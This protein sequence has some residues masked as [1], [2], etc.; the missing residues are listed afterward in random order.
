MTSD[1]TLNEYLTRCQYKYKDVSKR[2]IQSALSYYKELTA[3]TERYTYP[4]GITRELVSL[5]GTI[6]VNFKNSRYN[7]PI[8][9]YLSD[10]HPYTPPIC[11]VRPTP[12]MSINSSP[13]S[14]V[15]SS[16]KISLPCLREWNYPQFDLYT[17]ISMMTIKFSEETP[18]FA[19]STR[20]QTQQ[21]NTPQY[22]QQS[23]PSLPYP[24]DIRPSY[25]SYS[26]LNPS[27]TPQYPNNN[28]Y[29]YPS[30][31]SPTPYP[32]VSNPYL[33]MQYGK[34]Q[35]SHL[36]SGS[37]NNIGQARPAMSYGYADETIGPEF[38]KNSLISAIE[39]K[40]RSRY[41]E[42][43]GIKQ[44]ENESLK[45]VKLDLESGQESLNQVAIQAQTE[46]DNLKSMTIELRQRTSMI[47][48]NIKAIQHRDKSN[49]EDAVITPMPL[50]RQIMLLY[51]EELAVQDLIY[52]LG[53]G[54]LN[55]TISL[56]SFLRQVRFLSRK[57]FT[58][59]ATLLKA[60]EKAALP[61]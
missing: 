22:P 10:L 43:E 27:N 15:D 25:P 55:N 16:G 61:L 50:Y 28:S 34:P 35:V 56:D 2:D 18:L 57:Q 40:V 4:N 9:L 47:N 12:D 45:K 60:R 17:L 44:A 33:P 13:T 58:L 3:I 1:I 20:P 21:F 48:E 36:K 46:I 54:L 6:P 8:Q 51:A 23:N 59:R 39:E 52:Y 42:M 30:S 53:E 14:S 32:Q 41:R 49:V 19:R 29:P 11:Y 31:T 7:I 38:I 37:G 5:K 24:A 26:Q